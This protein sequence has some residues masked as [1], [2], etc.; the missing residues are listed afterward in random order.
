M[1]ARFYFFIPVFLVVF[2][3]RL[4]A[5]ITDLNIYP[6]P[7]PPI[8]PAAGN[9]FVDP[10][11][12]TTLLRVT[13]SITDGNDNHNAYSYWP[14]MNMNS[15]HLY[16]MQTN[17]GATLYDFDPNTF[18]ISNKHAAFASNCPSGA[19]PNVED[20]IWSDVD[21]DVIFVH[22]RDM[23]L[24]AYNLSTQ[25]YSLVKDLS[26]A[27]PAGAHSWQMNKDHSNDDLFSF[28]WKD[29]NWN[30]V[31]FLTWRSSTDQFISGSQPDLDECQPDRTGNYLILKLAA[32]GQFVVQA[33]ILDLATNTFTDITDGG[34]ANP[35]TPGLYWAPGHG[36]MGDGS[37]FGHDDWN[38]RLVGRSCANPSAF[39]SVLDLNND[40]SQDYHGSLLADDVNWITLS[41]Y[42]SN[43]LPNSGLFKDEIF[44]VATDG[45][46][47]VRRLAH[48]HS[49]FL[50]DYAANGSGAYWSSPKGCISKDGKWIVFTSNW[51][52]TTRRDVFILKVPTVITGVEADSSGIGIHLFPNP[53]NGIFT[54]VGVATGSTI[55]I[56]NEFG[57]MIFS[58]PVNSDRTTID[59]QDRPEGFYFYRIFNSDGDVVEGKIAVTAK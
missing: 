23:H 56:S 6:E 51:G 13:D 48:H 36:D 5:Q 20:A 37:V 29:V 57:E 17:I 53:S 42:V 34:P 10:T 26:T 35:N 7:A 22:D 1:S 58:T 8:L 19:A 2:V 47:S 44:Q 16:V 38:N 12:N 46:G 59:I 31:G 55:E 41:A 33:R 27:V 4:H 32:S 52:S 54:L 50:S 21:P 30:V 43:T 14:A 45:S 25:T 15:T 11:F 40:W 28:T 24:Y 9:T 3:C 49:D 18:S 39:Y